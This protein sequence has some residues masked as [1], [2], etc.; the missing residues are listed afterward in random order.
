MLVYVA[1]RAVALS[2]K[3]GRAGIY[4]KS[5]KGWYLYVE[6]ERLGLLCRA[7]RAGINA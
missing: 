7:E 1:V 5:R 4:V 2:C 6:P 3:A